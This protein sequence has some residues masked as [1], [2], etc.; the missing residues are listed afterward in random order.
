MRTSRRP[1]APKAV[2][3]LSLSVILL[4]SVAWVAVSAAD[5]GTFDHF[6]EALPPLRDARTW[7][8]TGKRLAN[9]GCQ[10]RYP[11]EVTEIPQDGWELRS[12]AVD[13]SRCRKL[14]EEGTPTVFS[15][16]LAAGTDSSEVLPGIAL[17]ETASSDGSIATLAASSTKSAWQI[18][19]WS[20]VLGYP[21]N[22]DGTEITWTYDGSA[23]SSGNAAGYWYKL[24]GWELLAKS[25]TQGFFSGAF[26]GQTT[27]TFRNQ[28][29]CFPTTVYTY[30]YYNRMWGHANGTATRAQSSDSVNECLPLHVTVSSAYGKWPY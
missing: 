13:T 8:L 25:V 17:A 23:V 19:V 18:V 2:A 7:V 27:A 20:D 28:G 5:P 22:Y 26:R 1:L 3:S 21:V 29:F 12:I 10:Y 16:D 24:G 14:M 15:L 6:R 11:T 4:A 9:G 30:Y